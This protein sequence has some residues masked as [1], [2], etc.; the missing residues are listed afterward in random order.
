MGEYRPFAD[1]ELPL[2]LSVDLTAREIRWEEIRSEGYS[3][4]IET[5][6]ACE[7]T[8]RPSL[9]ETRNSL[10]EGVST[11]EEGDDELL[12]ESIL[13]DDLLRYLRLDLMEC[14]VDMGECWVQS[15]YKL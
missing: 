6:Y 14:I 7:G 2:L 3:A 5:K 13:S 1:R 15:N 10:E 9:A 8:D 12:D 4:R 11:R